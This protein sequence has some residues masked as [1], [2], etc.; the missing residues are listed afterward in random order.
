MENKEFVV[1]VE[2]FDI[3]EIQTVEEAIT[4]AADAQMQ[5]DA[6]EASSEFN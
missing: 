6:D 3:S 2:A 1:K 4:P 5:A